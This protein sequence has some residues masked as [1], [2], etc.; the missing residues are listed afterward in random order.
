[1]KKIYFTVFVL[2][3]LCSGAINSGWIKESRQGYDIFY[4]KGDGKN[5]IEYDAFFQKGIY[6]IGNFFERPFKES[7]RIYIHPTRKSLDSTWQKDW[8]IPDFESQCWMVA[9]GVSQRLDI[10]SPRS[11]DSLSCEHRYR[12]TLKTY[13]LIKHELVH[14]FHGQ[15]NESPDFSVVEDVDWLV[16]GMATYVSGQCDNKRISEVKEV[17]SRKEYPRQLNVF[18]KGNSKYGLSGT[19]VMYIDDEFGRS[20]LI[21]LLQYNNLRD[22]LNELDITEEELICNWKNF[23]EQ[24]E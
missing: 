9:S 5:L 11:W 15:R 4:T 23:V 18:W 24:L 17:I 13:R 2:I 20:K 7:F 8:D 14:V 21:G 3:T 1:M 16:E 12:D 6:E 19:M 22:V 10:L